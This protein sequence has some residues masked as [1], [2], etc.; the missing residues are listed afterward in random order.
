MTLPEKVDAYKYYY[1]CN[2]HRC[3]DPETPGFATIDEAI[4]AK[5]ILNSKQHTF[6]NKVYFNNEL[7]S[8]KE[9]GLIVKVFIS[10]TCTECETVNSWFQEL[11]EL[12]YF[13]Q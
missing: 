9:K 1:V 3:N 11:I 8:W 6:N 7:Q 4:E 2:C 13:S 5:R 12:D 10:E